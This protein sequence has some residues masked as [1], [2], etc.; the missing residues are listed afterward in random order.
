MPSQRE[1]FEAWVSAPPFE[2]PVTRFPEDG[3]TWS[4]QYRHYDV[5]F[6]WKAWQAASAA[7]FER[8]AVLC[9]EYGNKLREIGDH[10]EAT[11]CFTCSEGIR[12][13]AEKLGNEFKVPENRLQNKER[14]KHE[15]VRS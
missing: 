6:A 11:G 5:Q 15:F 2:M 12:A 3:D 4:G 1:A 8:A 13:E 14:E 9:R 10:G 7:A